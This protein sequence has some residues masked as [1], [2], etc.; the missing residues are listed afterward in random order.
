M[1]SKS[2]IKPAP[3]GAVVSEVNHLSEKILLVDG[4]SILSRAFYGIPLLTT[5]EGLHTNAVYGF[6]NIVLHILD[7]QKPE[8]LAVCFDRKAPTFRHKMFEAYKGTRK[9]FPP[10]FQ[11]QVP[12]IKEV[13]DSMNIPHY[14][15][16]GFEADDLIGTLSAKCEAI[17]MDVLILSGDRDLL[18]LAS[19]KTCILLP[20]TTK[21]KTE[22]F[23]YFDK[24]VKEQYGVTPTEFIDMKALMGDTSDNIPGVAGIGEKGAG[25]IIQTYHSIENAYEHVDEIKPA[26][27]SNALREHYEDAQMSKVLAT[28]CRTAPVEPDFLSGVPMTPA[29]MFNETSY[30]FFKRLEF[31]GILSRFQAEESRKASWTP[32]MNRID[33]YSADALD[34]VLAAFSKQ[35]RIGITLLAQ[36]GQAFGLSFA[37]EEGNL[38]YLPLPPTENAQM[39][40]LET[41]QDFL[42]RTA[43][44]R[45]FC[46]TDLK[47]ICHFVEPKHP[48]RFLDVSVAAYLLNP[49]K[50]EYPYEELAAGYA[51]ITM[52]SKDELLGKTHL[53]EAACMLYENMAQ[54]ACLMSAAAVLSSRPVQKEL[55]L[56][57]MEQLYREIELPTIL[58][59][60]DL[61][62][63]GICVRRDLLQEYQQMLSGQIAVLEKQIYEEAG[64]DFNINSPKQLG[65]LLFEKM[66]L[67]GGKKTKSGYSTSA[68]ILEKLQ[69]DYPFVKKVLEYRT[70]SK[71]NSTYAEGLQSYISADGR[72]HGTF[73]QTITATGRISSTEPNL[74]NIPTR[75]ELGRQLRKVFV[76]RDGWTFVDADYSQIELRVLAAM[77][78]DEQLINAYRSAEDIHALTASWVFGVP[79]NEVT[80]ELRRNAKAVNFGIVYGISAFGLSEGLSISKK[81]ANAYIDKYFEV[82]PKLKNYLNG[83]IEQTKASGYSYT[84]FGRRRP[85]PEISSSNFMQ[86]SFGERI[87]M[88]SPIQGSAADIMKLA[89][90]KTRNAL[91]AENLKAKIVLQVH[92]EIIVECPEE[93]LDRVCEIMRREMTSAA[94]LPVPLEV[95][96]HT[97]SSWYDAK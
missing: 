92:D 50:S 88:N 7:E 33:S 57:G 59:L 43:Q 13:L 37:D 36:D 5:Q 38:S 17:G 56:A 83:L 62:K 23:V 39:K 65:T 8:H 2:L 90:I 10:E 66:G 28:I 71:L 74:Q 94:S 21:G 51:G 76:P 18:Q 34:E 1:D 35:E 55:A 45:I 42:D 73:N 31:K 78:G 67:P 79:L 19:G 49:L 44:N 72:I 84:M 14:E 41:F 95:D 26:K 52:Q 11:E 86:R 40:A 9:P 80:P 63:Q 46:T 75:T 53:P 47:Q 16:D 60:A 6:L 12:L 25:A 4:H 64:E 77:S 96:L 93:E 69:D 29:L 15:I 20:K 87:A 22:T 81:E 70:L 91:I 89:V 24:D 30:R 68:D 82:Y 48:E 32:H 58:C 97:G 3:G 61:E 27:A 54:M 85:V